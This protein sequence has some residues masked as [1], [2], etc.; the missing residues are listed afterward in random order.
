[1][2]DSIIHPDTLEKHI[3]DPDWVIIDC[4]FELSDPSW[5][6][7]MYLEDH[8]PN[9]FFADLDLDLSSPKRPGTGRHPLPDI[10]H[11]VNKFS[12]WGITEK[13]QV[14][15]YDHMSGA[16]SARLWCLLRYLGHN[17]VAVL[18]GGC[19]AWKNENRPISKTIPSFKNTT[20]TP[21]IH[22]EL[23]VTAREL[24]Q[25]LNNSNLLLIDSRADKRYKGIEEPI[26]RIAGH[27]PHA[28]NHFHQDNINE[29]GYFKSD[30]ELR[31]I[32]NKLSKQDI[33]SKE[34]IVYCGS[35]VTSC[36]NLVALQKIGFKNGKLFLGSWSEWIE[37]PS[38]PIIKP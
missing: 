13:T 17:N 36:L 28:V 7:K 3:N 29:E 15:V 21:N 5:G 10:T 34:I 12:C 26:D 24:E 30:Q 16:F 31:V 18:D 38:R 4:R 11:L 19:T 2:F 1:M 27:I 22:P 6:K 25:K 35:G 8:I 37:D 23:F 33:N 9:A 20:F 14:I 32:F